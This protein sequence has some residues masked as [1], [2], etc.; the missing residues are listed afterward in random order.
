MA[1]P[2]F[3][4]S[5]GQK[6]KRKNRKPYASKPRRLKPEDWTTDCVLAVEKIKTA[7]TQTAVL[8]HPDF[9]KPFVLFTDA[10]VDGLGTVL[11]QIPDGE[12]RP[13]LCK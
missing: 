12:K 5:A 9:K 2:L 1:K 7:V 6:G 8:V 3:A 10:S 13:S 4:L 11:C